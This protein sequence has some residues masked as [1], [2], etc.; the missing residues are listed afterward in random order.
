M[1][2]TNGQVI[3]G[4]NRG[5]EW[6]PAEDKVVFE[7]FRDRGNALKTRTANEIGR[8]IGR[9]TNAVLWRFYNHIK[10]KALG[11]TP[12]RLLSRYQPTET[13]YLGHRAENPAKISANKPTLLE[14]LTRQIAQAKIEVDKLTTIHDWL[15]KQS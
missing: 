1:L 6:M 11:K 3:L 8:R 15:V 10:P 5:R 7:G 9:S 14:S 4:N 2:Q 13:A 12:F